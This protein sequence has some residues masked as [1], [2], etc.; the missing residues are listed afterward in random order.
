[1]S[2]PQLFCDAITAFYECEYKLPT[3]VEDLIFASTRELVESLEALNA[4]SIGGASDPVDTSEAVDGSVQVNA[5]VHVD[6]DVDVDIS[7]SVEIDGSVDA[8]LSVDTD[9]SGGAS[10]S[11]LLKV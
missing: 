11:Y 3:S 2:Y 5:S 6:V 10:K 1:M 4:C 9:V 7:V 8:S